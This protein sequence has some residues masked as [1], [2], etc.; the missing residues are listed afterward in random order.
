MQLKIPEDVDAE[1]LAKRLV[2]Q[3]V[4]LR[5]CPE[6]K[7]E[8]IGHCTMQCCVLLHARDEMAKL[9]LGVDVI[10]VIHWPDKSDDIV[11][12]LKKPGFLWPHD[13]IR[14]IVMTEQQE[15][16]NME[17]AKQEAAPKK[18]PSRKRKT[19]VAKK[20]VVEK[21]VFEITDG[22]YKGQKIEVKYDD[23]GNP[24]RLYM[25]GMNDINPA[26]VE[27]LADAL[28]AAQEEAKRVASGRA[29]K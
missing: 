15:K 29:A 6:L 4:A 24:S 8:V 26:R 17:E 3:D 28:A 10:R 20:R 25:E 1:H 2:G 5:D 13:E 16:E 22:P 14:E 9:P 18:K 11:W 23:K 7:Y 27:V 19:A 12:L 21:A